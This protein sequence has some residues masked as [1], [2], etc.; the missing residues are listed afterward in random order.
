MKSRAGL[1]NYVHFSSRL[2]EIWYNCQENVVDEILALIVNNRASLER[3]QLCSNAVDRDAFSRIMSAAGALKSLRFLRVMVAWPPQIS[4]KHPADMAALIAR[5]CPNLEEIFFN[6]RCDIQNLHEFA[7]YCPRLRSAFVY[8][9]LADISQL[10]KST[11]LKH[12]F[13]ANEEVVRAVYWSFPKGRRRRQEPMSRQAAIDKILSIAPPGVGLNI[14]VPE[15]R[16]SETT[17]LFRG[18]FAGAPLAE[19]HELADAGAD[20]HLVT[21]IGKFTAWYYANTEDGVRFL[22]ERGVDLSLPVKCDGTSAF[23]HFLKEKRFGL[24]KFMLSKTCYS[25]IL[26]IR[27]GKTTKMAEDNL[28]MLLLR[29]LGENEEAEGDEEKP[30]REA[31]TYLLRPDVSSR[32]GIDVARDVSAVGFPAIHQL[33]RFG[34]AP[35][36]VRILVDAGADPLGLARDG[37]STPLVTCCCFRTANSAGLAKVLMEYESTNSAPMP[38]PETKS[39]PLAS[40]NFFSGACG[41]QAQY[42]ELI[43][44]LILMVQPTTA[45]LKRLHFANVPIFVAACGDLFKDE[46]KFATALLDAGVIDSELVNMSVSS[47]APQRLQQLH[48][49]LHAAYFVPSLI[50]RLFEAGARVTRLI[51]S[52]LGLYELV[53]AKF[54]LSKM[55]IAA[56]VESAECAYAMITSAIGSI[57]MLEAIWTALE[58]SSYR[59][60]ALSYRD[61][62]GQTF[63]HRTMQWHFLS[64]VSVQDRLETAK[65]ALSKGANAALTDAAGATA[66]RA[67]RN[68]AVYGID[69]TTTE[70]REILALLDPN[71]PSQVFTN[72]ID[73]SGGPPVT[74]AFRVG[75]P[76][77][78]A[79]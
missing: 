10:R 2:K 4:Q 51:M 9:E 32:L 37:I 45:E 35:E 15:V 36:Y 46:G 49:A 34:G 62:A 41:L 72:L 60:E 8:Y 65:W 16:N 33:C 28:L 79:N 12:V 70:F 69:T 43:Q 73:A 22:L 74:V 48:S 6:Y 67:A 63:L 24:F 23:W 66:G 3:L 13:T 7:T 30:E 44:K 58:P 39:S 19:L 14:L 59:G 78:G 54:I 18:L 31:L 1:S 26:R 56:D 57:E 64:S 53:D 29:H 5:N 75:L 27:H 20:P 52:K 40:D 55:N 25:Q 50:P 17:I 42:P 21:P 71:G 38:P 61:P 47:G 11:S 77:D 68:L 76:H